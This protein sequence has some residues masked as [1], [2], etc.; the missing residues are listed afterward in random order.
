MQT[1]FPIL[2]KCQALLPEREPE[3]GSMRRACSLLDTRVLVSPFFFPSSREHHTNNIPRAAPRLFHRTITM[4][5]EFEEYESNIISERK[6][7]DSDDDDLSD[8][9]IHR[10]LSDAENR[11]RARSTKH[12][13]EGKLVSTS[14]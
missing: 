6:Y 5:T 2:C 4:T 11:L 14:G 7:S 1:C 9:Q 12:A 8:Q 10:L 13:P 3:E